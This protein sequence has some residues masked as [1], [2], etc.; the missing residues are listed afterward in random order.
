MKTAGMPG[1][2]SLGLPAPTSLNEFLTR[3]GIQVAKNLRAA[4]RTRPANV[5]FQR[6]ASAVCTC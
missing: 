3:T 2:M 4:R 5:P 6:G 1:T